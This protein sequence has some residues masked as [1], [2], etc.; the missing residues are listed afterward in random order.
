MAK[1]LIV[2]ETEVTELAGETG[3]TVI[4]LSIDDDTQA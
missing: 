4:Y 2:E 1:H 3:A